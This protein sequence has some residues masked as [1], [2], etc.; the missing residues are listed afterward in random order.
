MGSPVRS[1]DGVAVGGDEAVGLAEADRAPGYGPFDRPGLALALDPAGEGG[2]YRFQFADP[3]GQGVGQAVGEV[4][5]RVDRRLVG[6]PLGGAGPSDFDT[7]EQIGLGAGHAEKAC[8]LEG[9]TDAEDLLI[10]LEAD[11]RALLLRWPAP[12]DGTQGQAAAEGLAPLMPVTPHGDVQPLAQGIDD[13]DTDA[14]QTA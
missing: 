14:M 4:K 6:D 8:R 11:Q 12:D 10:R 3:F 2:R 5:D 9:G 13:R 1:R 7:A